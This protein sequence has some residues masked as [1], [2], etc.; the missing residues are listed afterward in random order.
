VAQRAE[1]QSKLH[2]AEAQLAVARSKS[3]ADASTYDKLRA[4]AATPGVVAGNDLVLAQK[5]VEGDQ[6]EIAAAQ[7]TAEAARQAVQSIAQL[8]GYLRVTAPFD[9]VV[10]ERNVHP[11]TLV[12]PN[13][14]PAAATPML[15]VVDLDRLRLVVPIPEAY[16]AGLSAGGAVTFTVPAYPGQ[17]FSGTLARVA[18]AIDVQTRTMAVEI[19]VVNRDARLAPGTFC[20]VQWP[21]R[22]PMPSLLVPSGSIGSTSDRTFVVRVRDGKTE[23]VDVR[24]GLTSGP[25]VEVFGD[26][27]VGD[28]VAARGTDEIKPGTEVRAHEITPSSQQFEA[29]ADVPRVGSRLAPHQTEVKSMSGSELNRRVFLYMS[30]GGA[31]LIPTPIAAQVR[32]RGAASPKRN[33]KGHEA[34]EVAPPEDLMREHGVLKRVLLVYREV[35]RRVNAREDVPP[36]AVREGAGIIRRFIE[37]YHEKL[38]E[39]YLFPR[40]EK[41]GKL[42]DLTA[43]L[44][45]QHQAGR[46]LTELINRGATASALKDRSSA[47]PTVQ[48]MEQFIRM[49]EPHEARED[50]VL[51][52]ALRGIVS[53]H[54]FDALGEEFEKKEQQLFGHE[55]FEKIVDQV[56]GIERNLGI[57]DLAQFTPK[58]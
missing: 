12:G 21:V 42:A 28:T 53:K 56:A 37:D 22:R 32:E 51:F 17:T 40:F 38:E 24:T 39:D 34:E 52:P 10:T 5:S 25:L 2:A 49:Y 9:G 44:R 45:A 31:F 11:G 27:R 14:G 41:A 6:S 57:Y 35:I 30:A 15:R 13:S 19:D 3:D 26:L 1:A 50:T 16:T 55:G 46:R 54:E 48:A 33:D 43:V 36:D 29:G 18:N 23:W 20:K 7:Q 47:A 8:E 4:A 58:V